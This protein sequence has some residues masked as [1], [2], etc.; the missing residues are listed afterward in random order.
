MYS[1]EIQ[2]TMED[3]NYDLPSNVVMEIKKSS[4][5]VIREKYNAFDG[6]FE[7]WTNDSCYWRYKVHPGTYN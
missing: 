6:M 4:P 5:Q 2:K 1:F 7:M 3:Y